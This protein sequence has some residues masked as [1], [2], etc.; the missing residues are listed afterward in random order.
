MRS[1]IKDLAEAVLGNLHTQ[2]NH[3]NNQT[4]KV[5][6]RADFLANNYCGLMQVC[7]VRLGDGVTQI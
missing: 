2:L 1:V 7:V 5:A 6:E 4:G 3:M